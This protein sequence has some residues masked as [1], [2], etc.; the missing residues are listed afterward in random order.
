M[1]DVRENHIINAKNWSTH[2]NPDSM[3]HLYTIYESKLHLYVVF[4]SYLCCSK[5]KSTLKD[6]DYK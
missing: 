4:P 3:N 6:H 5:N 2:T 1:I